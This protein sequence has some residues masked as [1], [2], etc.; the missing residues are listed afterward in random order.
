MSRTLEQDTFGEDSGLWPTPRASDRNGA[1]RHGQGGI[2]LRTAVTYP[3]PGT[4]GLSNGSGN[5]GAVNTLFDKGV[6]GEEERRSMRSGGGGKLS[7]D[8]VERMMGILAGG[9]IY[10]KTRLI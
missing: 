3:T 1:G 9:R 4:H 8:W 6:I 10:K 5:V 2:D 7:A